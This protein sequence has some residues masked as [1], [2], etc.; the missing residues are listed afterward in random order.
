VQ[1]AAPPTD[2]LTA[3]HRAAIAAAIPT[4]VVAG[5]E[6]WSRLEEIVAGYRIFRARREHYNTDGER[7]KWRRLEKAV[8]ALVPQ[9]GKDLVLELGRKIIAYNA[10]L[11]S[12]RAYG[13]TRNPD[14]EFLYE[15]LLRLWT[16][17]LGGK[18][19]YSTSKKCPAYGPLVRFLT[20]CL[21]PVLGVD[22][23]TSGIADIVDR[24]RK[25]RARVEER[26]R[27]MGP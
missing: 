9:L 12:A 1:R 6:F 19:Q 7:G 23:P 13:G 17:H 21:R 22:T 27:L 14:R 4:G 10:Y 2:V 11:G 15:G 3:E 16:D 24:E 5:P 25:E 26:K 20:A 18:L 8:A